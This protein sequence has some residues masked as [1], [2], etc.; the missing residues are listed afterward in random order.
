LVRF[1]VDCRH[2]SDLGLTEF[3][4]QLHQAANALAAPQL[5]VTSQQWVHDLPVCFDQRIITQN[6]RLATQLNLRTR[7]LTAGAG[8]DSGTTSFVAPTAMLFV[9]SVAGISHAPAELTLPTDLAHGVALLTASLRVQAYG[10][11]A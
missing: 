11:L 9:P 1:T 6:Q 4:R 3:E 2:P 5:P 10:G 7:R 8:R